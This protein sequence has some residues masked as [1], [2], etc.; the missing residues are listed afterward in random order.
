MTKINTAFKGGYRLTPKLL[1]VYMIMSL[2][3]LSNSI[4]A[5]VGGISGSKISS[6]TVDVVNHHN[7]EF[8]PAFYHFNSRKR[9]DNNGNLDD[10]SVNSDSTKW[11]TGLNFRVTYGLMDKLELGVD[12]S[13]D[14]LLTRIGARYVFYDK[15]K[16]GLAAITGINIPMGNKTVSKSVR[17][18]NTIAKAGG[19]LVFTGYIL[20]DFSVDVN[21]QYFRFIEK[22]LDDGT[23]NWY[24]N[25]DFGYYLLERKLQLI[26]GFGY[27]FSKYGTFNTEVFTLYPGITVE[28]GK[29]YI[30]VL[31]AGIDVLGKNTDK[32][33]G[34]ALA[35]TIILD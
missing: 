10:F 21:A 33:I 19:G 18:S 16:T 12:F 7:V 35:L 22:T 15:E 8:E 13:S 14:M 2:F 28:T 26:A 32:N 1:I 31:S 9:W 24:L 3:A 6:Y 20:P 11:I 34:A 23:N 30:I 27:Q 29:Q 25:S 5:Q 4:N 17:L